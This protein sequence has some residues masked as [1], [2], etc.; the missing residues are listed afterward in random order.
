[1][2]RI[3]LFGPPRL[4][5]DGEPVQISRRKGLAL[6]AYL[7]HI[8]QPASRDTLAA[9]F[10]PENSQTEALKSLR[11]ELARL[12]KEVPGE[13]ISV[14]GSQLAFNH[15][16]EAVVDT[17]HFRQ[18]LAIEQDHNHFP[19]AACG[20]CLKALTEA[21]GLYTSDFLAGFNLLHCIEYDTWQDLQRENLRQSL[22]HALHQLTRWHAGQREYDR[23]IQYCRR[24]L[25]LDPLHEAARRTLMEVY[26]A[27][28]SPAVA[29][30]LYEEG[31]QLLQSE[32][33]VEPAEETQ[34]LWQEIRSGQLPAFTPPA[35]KTNTNHT[36]HSV[37]HLPGTRRPSTFP[38]LSTPFVGRAH[39]LT[40]IQLRLQE[41]A[42]RLINL[43]GPLGFGKTRVAIEIGRRFESEAVP[44]FPD[45]VFFVPVAS[46]TSSTGI[47]IAMLD[48]AGANIDGSLTPERQMVE[49]LKDKEQ[50]FILDN[51]EPGINGVEVLSTVLAAAPGIKILTTSRS[52][53]RLQE[54]WFHPLGGLSCPPPGSPPHELSTTPDRARWLLSY[55]AIQLFE[56][57]A[58][59]ASPSFC[60]EDDMESVVRICRL[61]EG[62]PLAL[63]LAAAWLRVLDARAV[64]EEL[65]QSLD[66]LDSRLRNLPERH[67]SIR[68]VFEQSWEMLA[69]TD[70]RVLAQLSVFRGGF[71]REAALHIAGATPFVLSEL[72]EKALL[73]KTTHGRYQLH[74][75][76]RQFAARKLE[77]MGLVGQSQEDH[78]RFYLAHLAQQEAALKGPHQRTALRQIKN[79]L[80]NLRHAWNWAVEQNRLAI[81]DLALESIFLYYFVRGRNQEGVLFLQPARDALATGASETP[82][83][84]WTRIV[85][86]MC[87]MQSFLAPQPQLSAEILLCL[88][89]SEK[90]G[91]PAEKAFCCFVLGAFHTLGQDD[92]CA[93]I[94]AYDRAVQYYRSIG[95]SFYLVQ[96]LIWMGFSYGNSADLDQYFS[97][98][99]EALSLARAHG[100]RASAANALGNLVGGALCIGDYVTAEQ[101][102]HE[103]G[104]IGAELDLPIILTHYK[105]Q[106]S[107]IHFLKGD[108]EQAGKLAKEAHARA[109]EIRHP[110]SIAYT[111]TF[112]SLD[113]SIQG[114]YLTGKRYS[115]E[116]LATPAPRFGVIL[117][118]WA[119]SIACCGLQL[120][121]PAWEHAVS[122]MKLAHPAGYI[123]LNVWPLPVMAVVLFRA[124]QLE[125]S[126][127]LLALAYTHPL[128]P[129]GW[130]AQWPLL[131]EVYDQLKTDLGEDVFSVAWERGLAL[132]WDAHVASLIHGPVEDPDALLVEV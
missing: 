26:A 105:T 111:L 81:L 84:L 18:H 88:S 64:A 40:M 122:M 116:S 108:F 44:A 22:G 97:L 33:G 129:T 89:A 69:P 55:D 38:R 132:D 24:W 100:H 92:F 35:E 106:L 109:V 76:L 131:G 10:W 72:I 46:V 67:Q 95:E 57:R 121:G 75:L 74:E 70:Q 128:S 77:E 54:E 60:L 11:R 2:L 102:T 41:P 34:R 123:A 28:G 14:V 117:A 16:S 61:V 12:K 49:A 29:L 118:H 85:S 48:A 13:I 94:K 113:A 8:N 120:D 125:P 87:L 17:L 80:E 91:D 45:G 37:Q 93:A 23:A 96:V 65:E 6:L 31:A 82:S 71:T 104:A 19:E 124:G 101:Y 32:L 78:C 114:D 36:H 66:L 63:E 59:S 79:N 90:R 15:T 126:V 73:H 107:L 39:E 47:L 98:T 27:E 51:V 20:V 4:E 53:L 99:R 21:V 68:A 1:M 130:L 52:A 112:L 58:R 9:L 127:E 115:E 83:P 119:A 86:R 56:Q 62:M 43:V 42:C 25:A 50:L 30:R 103:V 3:C 110:L 5:Y 7:S